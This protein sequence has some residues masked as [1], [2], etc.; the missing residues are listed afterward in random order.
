MLAEWKRY[1]T[2]VG[3]VEYKLY[4]EF[5]DLSSATINRVHNTLFGKMEYVASVYEYS[6]HP[7]E[8]GNRKNIQQTVH[9][10]LEEAMDWCAL[11]LNVEVVG[12]YD[13]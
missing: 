7:R 10:S 8:Y 5:Q 11:T 1:V 4:C 3:R 9:N 13:N 6:N 2:N 12:N